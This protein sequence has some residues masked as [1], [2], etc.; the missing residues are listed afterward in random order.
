VFDIIIENGRILDGAGNPWF[1]GDIGIKDGK[2]KSVGLLKDKSA[3]E[4]IDATGQFVSP[5]FIDIHSHSD[6]VPLMAKQDT[7]KILQGVTTEI[8]GVC[9]VTMTPVSKENIGL[10]QKYCAPFFSGAELSWDWTG[11]KDYLATVEK[12]KPI[13]NFGFFVGHGTIRIAVMGFE[14]REPSAEELELMKS[15][16]VQAVKEGAF[17]MSSGLVY[18]PGIFGKFGMVKS[19]H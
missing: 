13:V 5:G 7:G 10:L 6:A 18:P 15:L 16:A 19:A 14:N 9:G 2:I 11:V 3:K 12:A 8:V 17:G 1:K 4:R